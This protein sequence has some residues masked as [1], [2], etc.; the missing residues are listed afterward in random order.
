M[1]RAAAAAVLRDAVRVV[2]SGATPPPAPAGGAA[3][4]PAP[5]TVLA[6]L[7]DERVEAR[8][9]DE[10]GAAL[11]RWWETDE[12]SGPQEEVVRRALAVVREVLVGSLVPELA[13]HMENAHRFST[14]VTTVPPA[15]APGA[16]AL[17]A[18]RLVAVV[19][20]H[21]RGFRALDAGPSPFRDADV[22]FDADVLAR[23][24]AHAL[25]SMKIR[26]EMRDYR[27]VVTQEGGEEQLVPEQ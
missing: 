23:L 25:Q 26:F 4:P 19:R 20:E 13:P 9:G 7:S 24:P 1:G 2:R 15:P 5:P 11:R 27:W 17:P 14:A 21:V 18:P 16:P 6:A 3:D 12:P 22:T 8:L 10:V